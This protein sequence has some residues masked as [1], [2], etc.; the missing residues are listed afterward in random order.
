MTSDIHHDHSGRRLS[1][2]ESEK[3]RLEHEAARLFM[4][5]YEHQFHQS[6]RHIWHNDPAKPDI[7]C[8]LQGQK[9]DLE[10]A[11]LYASEREARI[12]SGDAAG[13]RE[14]EHY[15]GSEHLWAYLHDLACMD[16][17]Q[18]LKQSLSRILTSKA[19]KHYN[20]R[21]CWLI[22]RNASPL[23]QRQEFCQL[24][25]HLNLPPHPFEQIWVVPDFPG[26]EPLVK[27][28]PKITTPGLN[29]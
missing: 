15:H 4:R 1:A 21:R 5:A 25:P 8:Y 29:K 19:R 6:I 28:F 12:A 23:W 17:Q 11:H 3:R 13:S 2:S 16:W 27:L 7:S 24:L 14:H 26:E 20:S 10:I 18:R 9:L 22:I